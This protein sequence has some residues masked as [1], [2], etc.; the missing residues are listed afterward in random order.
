[1]P[2]YI[3]IT[4]PGFPDHPWPGERR[5][6]PYAELDDAIAQAVS[7]AAIGMGTALG[8]YEYSDEQETEIEALMI[9]TDQITQIKRPGKT[10]YTQAQIEDE[11]NTIRK[12]MQA[13]ALA[14]H[15]QREEM[16]KVILPEGITWKDMQALATS[17]REEVS[18]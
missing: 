18:R 9:T 7:D 12:E 13:K 11:A 16:M 6:G 4:D 3:H 15:Q 2:Y 5:F 10:V 14:D 1:M 8:I 17:L